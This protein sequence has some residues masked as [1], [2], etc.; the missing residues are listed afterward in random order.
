MTG[1]AD[2]LV[3]VCLHGNRR[4][5]EKCYLTADGDEV[6]RSM[7]ALWRS[8]FGRMRSVPAMPEPI[9]QSDHTVVMSHID[10][11]ARW[12]RGDPGRTEEISAQC[13]GLLADLH[14]SGVT[15]GRR[16]DADQLVGSLTRKVEAQRASG[17]CVYGPYRAAVDRLGE[18]PRGTEQLVVSH[19][20]FWPG[21]VLATADGPVLIDFDR[22]QMASPA[23][24][25]SYWAA[26]RWATDLMSGREPDWSA[27]DGFAHA[28]RRRV[29]PS[30]AAE[31]EADLAFHRA[32][33]L[34]RIAS[35]SR[36][37]RQPDLAL[38]IISEAAHQLSR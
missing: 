13:A 15:V 21:N 2:R 25:V 4:V 29:S 16:R 7:V 17:S 1:H 3:S 18:L 28:Y 30:V 26:W 14:N 10:G 20:D 9:A 11:E 34:L 19:G 6:F 24:D 31:L 32:A 37:Q 23:L 22:L 33:G 27:S 12:Y 5:V 38:Q 8:P 36:A 35:Q